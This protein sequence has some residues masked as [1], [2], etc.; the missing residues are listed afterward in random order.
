MGFL[1]L[2][3]MIGC[4]VLLLQPKDKNLKLQDISYQYNKIY[5]QTVVLIKPKKKK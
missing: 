4:I 5:D 1:L 3:T 2:V